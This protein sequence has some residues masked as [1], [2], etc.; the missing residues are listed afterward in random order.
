MAFAHVVEQGDGVYNVF[1]DNQPVLAGQRVA[2]VHTDLR[3]R[4]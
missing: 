1:T 2:H 4:T 3:D